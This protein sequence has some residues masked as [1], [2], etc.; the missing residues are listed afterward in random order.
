MIFLFR[1]ELIWIQ[2]VHVSNE[3]FAFSLHVNK[4]QDF[5]LNVVHQ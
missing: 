1:C 3:L 5:P 2:I 4:I